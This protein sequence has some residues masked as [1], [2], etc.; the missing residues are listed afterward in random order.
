M[1]QLRQRHLKIGSTTGYNR[2]IMAVL[3]P[4]CAAQGFDA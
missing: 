4:L 2:E 3:A 1:A